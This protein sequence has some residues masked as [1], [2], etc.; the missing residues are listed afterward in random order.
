VTATATTVVDLDLYPVDLVLASWLPAH[1]ARH[2]RGL[3]IGI[4]DDTLVVAVADPAN[5]VA[6]ENLKLALGGARRPIRFVAAD[7]TQLDRLIGRAFATEQEAVSAAAAVDERDDG[8]LLEISA[9]IEDAPIVRFLDRLVAQ[10]VGERASDI[11]FEPGEDVL[12]VRFRVD[13]VLRQ[14]HA[15]PLNVAPKIMNRLKV[16][17]EMEVSERRR[18]QDGRAT[19]S[20]EGSRVELRLATLPTAHG[21]RATVRVLDV[22]S[23]GLTLAELGF[24]PSTL[25]RLRRAAH[26]PHGTVLV[27]GPTG[28]GKTTTLYAVL[29]ELN[30]PSRHLVSVEDPVE[31]QISGVTQVQINARTGL[32]FPVALR[33]ILRLDPDVILVGEI[34][35]AETL[36]MVSEAAL[37]GHLVLST[38]HTNSAATT[39]LRLAEMGLEP[40]LISSAFNCV[41]TQRLAR[42]LCVH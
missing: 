6:T 36:A 14:V 5:L 1:V 40:Y 8:S 24:L 32:T 3:P 27:T 13:G 34:R 9:L 20:V 12:R 42:R 28:S 17:G 41:L 10:A 29:S 25:E 22:S 23:A 31:R 16:L 21:E 11:H 39:P 2:N 37:T 38:L 18:P 19:I 15:L 35:D 30:A 33:S 4:E 26:R 7:P